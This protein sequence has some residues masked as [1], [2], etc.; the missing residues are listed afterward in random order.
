MDGGC[1]TGRNSYWPLKYGA[2]SVTGFDFDERKVQRATENLK[3]FENANIEY[4]S[5]YDFDYKNEFD[6]S[7]SI[8]VVHILEDSKKAVN[9]LIDATKEGGKVL[10]WVYGYE[11]VEW[12]VRYINPIRRVTSI[13]PP[14]MV[15]VVSYFFSAPL[16]LFLKIFPHKHSYYELLS[17]F[18]VWHVHTI[19]VD[20]LV[21]PITGY[22][23]KE[24]AIALMES[25][26]LKD[27]T[28]HWVNQN[29]WA[30]SG[31]KI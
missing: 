18:K 23:T 6:I 25:E 22:L 5:F 10:I 31:T 28:A 4:K 29:S 8:G 11:G 26:H 12:V 13:L 3:D 16:F 19:V 1:G 9:K 7:F 24:E 14:W 21:S 17:R 30:V 20:Q 27:I 15:D 2:E